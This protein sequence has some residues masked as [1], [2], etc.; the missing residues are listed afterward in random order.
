MDEKWLTLYHS[1]GVVLWNDISACTRRSFIHNSGGGTGV[2]LYIIIPKIKTTKRQNES[3]SLVVLIF[4]HRL[5]ER[6]TGNCSSVR[7]V[8]VQFMQSSYAEAKFLV[9]DWG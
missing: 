2:Q 9:I 1:I 7:A 5:K 8:G 4:Y 3:H 6:E